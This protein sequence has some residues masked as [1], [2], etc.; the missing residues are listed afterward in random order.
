MAA[1]LIPS[2]YVPLARTD[3]DWAFDITFQDEDWTGAGV[4][5][6]M[7]RR[8][9]PTHAV[10]FTVGD[11]VLAP[12]DDLSVALR[13]PAARLADMP[14]GLYS[15]EVRRIV[16]EDT[17]DA[18]VFEM[19]LERGLAEHL[20]EARPAGVM[21][22]DAGAATG[23]VIVSRQHVVTVVRAAGVAGRDGVDGTDGHTPTP[24]EIDALVAPQ[25]AAAV[26]PYQA[27]LD[28]LAARVAALEEGV[29]PANAW[30][31]PDNNPVLRAGGGYWLKAS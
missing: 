7:A 30:R 26:A 21:L 15:A 5:V 10:E 29:V 20:I 9:L 31:Y 4:S 25:V 23:G 19:R 11:G 14:P 18:A 17:D 8:G 6:V 28:D 3:A 27:A 1:A 12:A 13:V 22:G 24:E 16:G 2:G